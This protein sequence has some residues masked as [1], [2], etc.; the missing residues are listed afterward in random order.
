MALLTATLKL[1]EIRVG[2]YPIKKTTKTK[3]GKKEN[4]KNTIL[5][6]SHASDYRSLSRE[7]DCYKKI[8]T[9][10]VI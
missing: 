4:E 9:K 7:G 5:Y 10:K 6:F 1:L 2:T 8:L 3:R